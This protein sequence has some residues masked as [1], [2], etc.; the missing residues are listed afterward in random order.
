MSNLTILEKLRWITSTERDRTEAFYPSLVKRLTHSDEDFQKM[1]ATDHK[2][3]NEDGFLN[4]VFPLYD[5]QIASRENYI[6]TKSQLKEK[7]LARMQDGRKYFLFGFYEKSS[8]K[9]IGGYFYSMPTDTISM[10]MRFFD[11]DTNK[12]TKTQVTIDF[13]AEWVF[14]DFIKNQ[15]HLKYSHGLDHYPNIDRAGLPLFKL[16]VGAL[17]YK[18]ETS[19]EISYDPLSAD[20]QKQIVYF[21][22]VKSNDQMA[23]MNCVYKI[24]QPGGVMEEL[25]KVTEWAGLAFKKEKI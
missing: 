6:F 4:E 8:S 15:G 23:I 5:Q 12:N 16:K 19:E 18:T 17:P 20:F 10:A 3:I 22:D 13:W 9:L 24:E 2:E 7:Y 11:R 1:F 21:S 14:Y 25:E